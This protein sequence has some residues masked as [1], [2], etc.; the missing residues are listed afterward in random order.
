MN[1]IL[2]PVLAIV[3]FLISA[4]ERKDN[5]V[6]FNLD[7]HDTTKWTVL[8]VH[9]DVLTDT[10]PNNQGMTLLT[11]PFKFS[12]YAKFLANKTAPANV[13]DVEAINLIIKIDSGAASFEFARD[14]RIFVNEVEMGAVDN[15]KLIEP[16]LVIPL[17][18]KEK[19][20]LNIIP[21]DQYSFRTD[22]EL[23]SP[24]P[25]SVYVSYK[26][27]FRLKSVPND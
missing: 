14:L 13:R 1:R 27:N 6:S 17:K 26:L 24:L 21:K 20:W 22:F 10:F 25:D 16:E 2:L 5:L 12:S 11:A 15:A 23:I 18:S 7:T 8:E 19:D 3:A 9:N 4:C